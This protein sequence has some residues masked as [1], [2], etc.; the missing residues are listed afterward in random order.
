MGVPPSQVPPKR[1]RKPRFS[2]PVRGFSYVAGTPSLSFTRERLV[3]RSVV[4][5]PAITLLVGKPWPR[6]LHLG[7][8]FFQR[9]E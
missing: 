4:E 6:V 9:G 7:R 2:P 3:S 1:N 5:N 8:G